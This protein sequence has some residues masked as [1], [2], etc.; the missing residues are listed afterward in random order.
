LLLQIRVFIELYFVNHQAHLGVKVVFQCLF[1]LSSDL[2][3][4]VLFMYDLVCFVVGVD[5][6]TVFG[7][8]RCVLFVINAVFFVNYT[9]FHS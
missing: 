3:R 8:I 4:L 7:F 5:N 1:L 6:S 9:G 2:C